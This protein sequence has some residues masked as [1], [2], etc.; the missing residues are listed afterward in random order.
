MLYRSIESWG[1]HFLAS[2]APLP[3]LGPD[4]LATR[5]PLPARQD[6]MEWSEQGDLTREF[7]EILARQIPV[8]RIL[9][10]DPNVR[11]T[12]DQPYNE[13]FLIRRLTG[14]AGSVIATS[15]AE[16]SGATWVVRPSRA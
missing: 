15:N 1:F 16:D 11:I 12:D 6:L 8:E 10:P 7:G 4:D 13:Y 14:A 5:L 2:L 3:E 9:S